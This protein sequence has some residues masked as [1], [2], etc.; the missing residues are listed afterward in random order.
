M[1]FLTIKS[2]LNMFA[3]VIEIAAFSLIYWIRWSHF[4]TFECIYTL[5]TS[6]AYSF[7][8]KFSMC[9][10]YSSHSPLVLQHPHQL[11]HFLDC[12]Y[13]MDLLKVV[14]SLQTKWK[15]FFKK[16]V[17]WAHCTE[18][19]IQSTDNF[20]YL[21]KKKNSWNEIVANKWKWNGWIFFKWPLTNQKW[22]FSWVCHIFSLKLKQRLL[23]QAKISEAVDLIAKSLSN[24]HSYRTNRKLFCKIWLQLPYIV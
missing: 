24:Q 14:F 19:L 21:M 22:T 12:E 1:N 17:F 10:F 4:I 8:W 3:S 13:S 6:T 18:F 5:M 9:S 23:C 16:S 11:N 20:L 2:K 7:C 15:T